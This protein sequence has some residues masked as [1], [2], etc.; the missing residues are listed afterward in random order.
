MAKVGITIMKLNNGKG[1]A[2]RKGN[3]KAVS[4]EAL[5]ERFCKDE[6][7]RKE[8]TYNNV[9]EG[10]KSGIELTHHITKEAEEYSREQKEN[11][12]RSLRNDAIIGYACIVK[13][14]ADFING[15]DELDEERF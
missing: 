1:N 7:L 11:G 10:Y 13:P 14:S 12:G 4:C 15:L 9:Y 2:K 5:K 8:D 3:L 6:D